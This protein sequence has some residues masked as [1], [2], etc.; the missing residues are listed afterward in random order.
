M[1]SSTTPVVVKKSSKGIPRT[2]IVLQHLGSIF[3]SGF[4]SFRL[5]SDYISGRSPFVEHFVVEEVFAVTDL[6]L[7]FDQAVFP[8]LVL[9]SIGDSLFVTS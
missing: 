6:G 8:R 7:S 9:T 2:Q 4:R 5:G 1:G 3:D